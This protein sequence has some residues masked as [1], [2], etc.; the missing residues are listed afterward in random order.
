MQRLAADRLQERMNLL[1]H[2][3]IK[4]QTTPRRFVRNAADGGGEMRATTADPPPPS[5]A[6]LS[7]RPPGT[8]PQ[9]ERRLVRC[10]RA[11]SLSVSSN[12]RRLSGRCASAQRVAV[13]LKVGDVVP[14]AVRAAVL[15]GKRPRRSRRLTGPADP[16]RCMAR[17]TSIA[18]LQPR[19]L[20]RARRKLGENESP[21]D[22]NAPKNAKLR[23]IRMNAPRVSSR[24]TAPHERIRLH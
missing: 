18:T 4:G 19:A 15:S 17:S 6:E 9:G 21:K 5:A 10:R 12:V 11:R 1:C 7:A 16:R 24:R 14:R 22:A 3:L 13:R 2:T 20:A 8:K 23:D